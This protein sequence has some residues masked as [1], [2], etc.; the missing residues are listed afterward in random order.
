MRGLCEVLGIDKI[1]IT[2][3][4]A[5]TNGAV[6]RFHRTLNAMLERVVSD[7]E[8]DW[9]VKLPG[10][11][12]PYRASRHATTGYSSNF[13]MFGRELRASIDIVLGGAEWFRIHTHTEEFIEEIC[14][15]LRESYALAREQ[16]GKCAE[17]NKHMY[18]L[19]V[20]P[21]KF[22]VGTW[23]WF[24]NARRY[25][26]RSPKWQ[27]NYT[28]P[29]FITNILSTV[30][31]VIQKSRSHPLVVHTDKLKIY[32]GD[33]PSTWLTGGGG[34]SEDESPGTP[35]RTESSGTRGTVTLDG[36]RVAIW[37]HACI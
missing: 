37:S 13:L 10:V 26:G 6:E 22:S 23:V 31:V 20:R 9:D 7:N 24:F 19:R 25:I 8:L 36:A 27:R 1:R 2:P 21:A 30:T 35:V 29:F 18:D 14:T 16:L 17:R 33:T 12:A 11:M 5:S 4:K 28:G 15:G 3:Y 32:L 34:G